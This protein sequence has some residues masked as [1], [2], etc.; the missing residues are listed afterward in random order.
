MNFHPLDRK[1]P[2][3]QRLL[4]QPTQ[5]KEVYSSRTILCLFC[6]QEG[7]VVDLRC[8]CS[9]FARNVE[10]RSF[11]KRQGRDKRC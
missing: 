5:T 6:Y 4:A 7:R 3:I 10:K 8:F 9:G 1:C 2:V 11:K